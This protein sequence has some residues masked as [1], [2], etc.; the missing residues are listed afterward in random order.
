ML[1]LDGILGSRVGGQLIRGISGG[2]MKRL[3]IAVE[4]ISLPELIFL[5][6]PTTGL[7]SAIAHEVMSAVRNLANFNR[8]VI[9]TIH[10]PP[11]A[12]FKVR[13]FVALLFRISRYF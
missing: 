13:S 8:T 5:D 2:Q 7:D 12:T 1:G 11:P 4:I 3:S 6:E 9:A 10:Q